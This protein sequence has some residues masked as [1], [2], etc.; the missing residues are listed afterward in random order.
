MLAVSWCAQSQRLGFGREP[1]MAVPTLDGLLL[2]LLGAIR[3]L[4]HDL[5]LPS[6]LYESS[7]LCRTRTRTWTIRFPAFLKRTP[8][9]RITAELEGRVVEHALQDGGEIPIHFC[10]LAYPGLKDPFVYRVRQ[11]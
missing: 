3:A 9:P 7:G 8:P 2:N 4:F 11:W 10:Q 6:D 5:F 1:L